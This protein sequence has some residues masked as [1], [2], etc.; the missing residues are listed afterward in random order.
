VTSRIG[1]IELSKVTRLFGATCALSSVS[2]RFEAGTITFLLG[3][4]GAGKSTLLSIIGTVLQPTSGVVKYPPAGS[5]LEQ[6]RRQVGW[7]AHESRCYRE[8]TGRQ[9]VEFA[10]RLYGIDPTLAWERVATLV[11]IGRFG[12]RSVGTLSRGQ[13]QRVAL[14]RALVH[15]PRV[16]LMDEPWSG[17]DAASS[18][19]LVQ[20][21]QQEKQRGTL[22]VVVTHALDVVERLGGRRLTL[23]GGRV[24]DDVR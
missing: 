11:G 23:E 20:V 19:R 5:D 3:P 9:N 24:V 8:L 15:G 21:L 22:I 13:R 10:A 2:A 18:E 1:A 6:I 12:E 14:A 16:L 4:N 7:V 17:L